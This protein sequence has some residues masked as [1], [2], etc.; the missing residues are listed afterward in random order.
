MCGYDIGVY[1]HFIRLHRS[2]LVHKDEEK[3]PPSVSPATSIAIM[4]MVL[5][6]EQ[7]DHDFDS[8]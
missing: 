3:L 1:Q 5:T 8:Q 7:S 2:L 6:W 4:R